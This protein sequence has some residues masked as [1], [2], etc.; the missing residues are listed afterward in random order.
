MREQISGPG[1]KLSRRRLPRAVRGDRLLAP[2]SLQPSMGLALLHRSGAA[3][4][5]G[6]LSGAAAAVLGSGNRGFGHDWY[7]AH[8][9][10]PGGNVVVLTN[11]RLLMLASEEFAQFEMEVLS[12][13]RTQVGS[14]AH[15][16]WSD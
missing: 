3:G 1:A 15:V 9:T 16:R 13:R 2:F 6:M 11:A 10:L 4:L 7:E 12:G 14:C 8:V 5:A